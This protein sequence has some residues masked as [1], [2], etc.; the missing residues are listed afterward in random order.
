MVQSKKLMPIRPV[1]S[2]PISQAKTGVREM[3]SGQNIGKIVITKEP[4]DTVMVKRLSP[5]K[6]RA[7]SLLNADTLSQYAV[8]ILLEVLHRS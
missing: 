2:F 4:N 5:L 6:I 7:E 8:S 3:Q 1:T